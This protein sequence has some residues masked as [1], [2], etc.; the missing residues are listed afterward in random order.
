MS[1]GRTVR[2][3][4]S[5]FTGLGSSAITFHPGTPKR[6]WSWARSSAFCSSACQL[7]GIW[8]QVAAASP[9][10]P[11]KLSTS[12]PSGSTA[13]MPSPARAARAADWSPLAATKMSIGSGGRSKTRASSTV[14]YRPRCDTYSPDHSRRMTS[15][16]SRSISWRSSADGHPAPTTCSLSRSPAPSPRVNRPSLITPTVAAAWATIA[17]W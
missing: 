10:A 12:S 9:P 14:K 7:M 8:P 6:N 1:S 13:Q 3:A 11:T 2:V 16:A 5:K 15:I 4:A 17:G